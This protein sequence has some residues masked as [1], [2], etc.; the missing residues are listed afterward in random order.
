M[1]W[2]EYTDILV[3]IFIIY[4]LAYQHM[5]SSQIPTMYKSIIYIQMI[6]EGK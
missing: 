3:R 6:S 2:L 5:P 1:F 4:A